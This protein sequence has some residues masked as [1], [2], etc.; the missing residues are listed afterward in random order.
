VVAAGP[1]EEATMPA[2]E[3]FDVTSADGT[4]IAV[5]GAGGGPP[6]VMVHGAFADHTRF[7]PLVEQLGDRFATFAMD[8]RGRGASGDGGGAVYDIERE[9]EDVAAVVDAVAERT[10]GP[11]ALWGHSYGAD[12]A[13]GGA[14]RSGGV[15]HLMLYEPGLGSPF[16]PDQVEAAEQAVAA[17]DVEEAVRI[18]VIDIVGATDEELEGMRSSPLWPSRLAALPTMPRELRAEG[19]WVY[20]PGQFASVTASTLVLAGSES[21]PVQQ[22]ATELATAALPGA[23]V[24][25]LE[26]HGHF[27]IQTDPALVAGIIRSFVSR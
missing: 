9:F 12:C 16:E 22:T 5:W 1:D 10:G 19:E 13:M 8:R 2:V 23:R 6:L 7:D 3:R 11:V 15:S 20:R 25:V 26:G 18:V 27:A 14:A 21:P 24:Q 4:S 17:G